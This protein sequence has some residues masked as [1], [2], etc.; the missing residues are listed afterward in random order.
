MRHVQNCYVR[1]NASAI[2]NPQ[3]PY[4]RHTPWRHVDTAGFTPHKSATCMVLIPALLVYQVSHTLL[5]PTIPIIYL[6]KIL[7]IFMPQ[8]PPKCSI[9]TSRKSQIFCW[10]EDIPR[11][12][13][14]MALPAHWCAPSA[15]TRAFGTARALRR[16][17]ALSSISLGNVNSLRQSLDDE[18]LLSTDQNIT[19][20]CRKSAIRV[21]C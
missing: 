2:L 18:T 13:S 20:V 14:H 5:P 19:Y 11:F 4:R 17:H 3:C 1:G 6:P 16:L 21:H 9:S 12:S 8:G 7:L 10:D 15:W